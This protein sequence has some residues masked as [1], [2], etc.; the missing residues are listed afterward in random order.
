MRASRECD[1]G[2][3]FERLY[4]FDQVAFVRCASRE[5]MHVVGHNAVG[6]DEKRASIRVFSKTNDDPGGEPRIRA[7]AAT[8][9]KTQRN[10]KKTSAAI[11]SGRE[12]NVFAFER[13][14]VCHELVCSTIQPRTAGQSCRAKGRGATFTPSDVEDLSVEP[15]KS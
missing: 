15:L 12:P 14:R 8:I 5:E 10:E 6:V 1:C 11:T 9:R 7:E 4:E 3:L 13:W 2:V